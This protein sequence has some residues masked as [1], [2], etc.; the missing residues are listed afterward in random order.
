[1]VLLGS[2]YLAIVYEN[3]LH[4]LNSLEAFCERA[5]E[6]RIYSKEHTP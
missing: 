6:Y 4:A 1:M 5:P 2:F 3:D